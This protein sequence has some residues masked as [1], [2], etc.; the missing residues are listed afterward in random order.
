MKVKICGIT[1][2]EDALSSINAGCDAL[3]FVFYKKSPRYIAPEKAKEII[4]KLPENIIKIGVFVN[5]KEKQ[6]RRI[7]ELCNLGMLQ[8]H[9]DES[10][11]FCKKFAAYKVIKVFRLR[12]KIDLSKILR[13]N[14]FAYLFDT[15]VKHKPGGTGARFNWDLLSRLNIK[16]PIFLS[17]GL[18]QKNIQQAIKTVHPEWV[19]VSSSVELAPGKKD[20]KKVNKF[21]ETVKEK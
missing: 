3:G 20:P 5:E 8:F 1:N 10:P 16:Q 9:G 17:G 13:Y 12:E 6:I 7:A 21:I 14:T 11:K 19:D 4:K 15:F 2:L 18:N